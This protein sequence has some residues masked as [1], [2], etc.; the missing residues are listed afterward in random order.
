MSPEQ[1][2]GSDLDGRTDLFSFGIV[3]YEM[4]TGNQ[5]FN[6]HTAGEMLEAIFVREP[7][8]PVKLNSKV[9]PDLERII[10]KALEKDSNLRY[11]SAADM[12]TDLQRV[13]AGHFSYIDCSRFRNTR[14]ACSFKKTMDRIGCNIA[15]ING[16]NFLFRN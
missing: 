13:E 12:R 10:P 15:A 5:P 6:G 3:L 8:E 1:A 14:G 4:V 2:R 16:Y 9:P 11:Q 7:V